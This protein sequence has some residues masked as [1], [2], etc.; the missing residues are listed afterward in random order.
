MADIPNSERIAS[1]TASTGTGPSE[2]LSFSCSTCRARKV[3]CDKQHPCSNCVKAGVECV[4]L[5]PTRGKRKRTKPVKEGLHAKLK[6]YKTL[7]ESHGVVTDA[8]DSG[9]ISE[10][11]SPT[12]VDAPPPDKAASLGNDAT[13]QFSS[14]DAKI[15][16]EEG[17]SRYYDKYAPVSSQRDAL[18]CCI[19]EWN[20]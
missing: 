2:R 19:S 12:F 8:S 10:E 14:T 18:R 5:S 17:S 4:F 7:L 1:S 20:R 16:H 3:R 11:D 15:V 6:R 13:K 9:D